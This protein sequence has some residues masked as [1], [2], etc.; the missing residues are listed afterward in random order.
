M[1]IKYHLTMIFTIEF[2]ENLTQYW[3]KCLS[4]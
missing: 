1:T 4:P 3:V 2:G